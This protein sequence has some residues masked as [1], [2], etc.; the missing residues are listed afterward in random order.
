MKSTIWNYE[1]NYQI[2]LEVSQEIQTDGSGH[3][4]AKVEVV[5]CPIVAIVKLINFNEKL[6]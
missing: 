2:F 3:D 4:G 6:I 1:T 5:L